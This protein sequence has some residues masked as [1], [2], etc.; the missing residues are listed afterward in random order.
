MVML[1]V[2]PT[3]TVTYVLTSHSIPQRATVYTDLRLLL[4]A[5]SMFTFVLL[6]RNVIEISDNSPARK[7]VT[8]WTVCR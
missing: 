3:C 7:A 5:I 1:N 8:E 4:Y 6:T 2:G